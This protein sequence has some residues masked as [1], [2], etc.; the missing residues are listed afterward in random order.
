M[1]TLLLAVNVQDAL[2]VR[3]AVD[4]IVPILERRASEALAS[5]GFTPRLLRVAAPDQYRLEAF[6]LGIFQAL[7]LRKWSVHTRELFPSASGYATPPLKNINRVVSAEGI[8]CVLSAF[9]EQSEGET[10]SVSELQRLLQ[11]T[12]L[13]WHRFEEDDRH[14]IQDATIVVIQFKHRRLRIGLRKH[15]VKVSE[16]EFYPNGKSIK[17]SIEAV[18]ALTGLSLTRDMRLKLSGT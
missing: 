18:R 6:E 9:R 11:I 2:L 12:P 4:E 5:A 17:L 3:R 7:V 13:E 8:L 15:P 10:F 1:L 16:Q 14:F